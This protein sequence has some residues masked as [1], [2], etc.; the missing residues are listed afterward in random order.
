MS[1]ST[2]L[3]AFK[4][5][6]RMDN[7]V[8]LVLNRLFFPGDALQICRFKGLEFLTDL[9]AGDANG[10]RQV[11]ATDEY[12]RFFPLMELRTPLKLLDL[13]AN[14]GG[15]P[16]L[17]A[18]EDLELEKIVCVELNPKT[19]V[20]LNFNLEKNFSGRFRVI[21]AA[22][23]GS[24][25]EVSVPETAG[26]TGDSIYAEPAN[27]DSVTTVRGM[28][29]DAIA[30]AEFGP[31]KIDICKID[32]EG[33]EFEILAGPECVRL[34]D[35]AYILIEIHHFR[36][37]PRSIIISKLEEM[38]FEELTGVDASD[39]HHHVHLFRKGVAES[40]NGPQ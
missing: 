12:R 14:N 38:G 26:G 28:T 27:G 13:G 33:A 21:N 3:N 40:A 8:Q 34:K 29:F 30:D 6:M 9:D 1:L 10:A 7:G 25:R 18:S 31:G 16:L 11:L 17:A 15:F 36:E 19:C 2:K 4:E 20:R 22:V 5:M 37:R 23:C 24:E 39:D 35:C 32:V